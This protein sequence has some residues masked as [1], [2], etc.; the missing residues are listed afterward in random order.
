MR[1][2][3]GQH[4]DQ[5][6]VCSVNLLWQI[7]HTRV[8]GGGPERWPP[9]QQLTMIAGEVSAMVAAQAEVLHGEL[10]PALRGAGL[11]ILTYAELSHTGA[12]RWARRPPPHCSGN[13]L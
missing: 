7:A 5:G 3:A 13:R 2:G 4:D 6:S 8:Q 12:G 10:L 11:R 9:E 1:S